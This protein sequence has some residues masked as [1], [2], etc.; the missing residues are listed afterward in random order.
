MLAIVDINYKFIAVD[1]NSGRENITGNFNF[2]QPRNLLGTNTKISHFLIG[3]AAFALDSYMMKP[4]PRKSAK[5]GV[6]KEIFN[7]RL[8]RARR[9]SENAFGLLSQ[10]FR[11]FYCNIAILPETC[12][13]LI[14]VACCL[15]NL[16][17]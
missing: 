14:L 11:I 9:V 3:D 4:Y 5:N 12:V 1:I 6:S 15:H 7:Y 10:V 13:D 17:T 8:C 16:A 2:P